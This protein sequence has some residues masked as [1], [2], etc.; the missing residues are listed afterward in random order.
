MVI[1]LFLDI[2]ADDIFASATDL[3]GT[4]IPPVTQTTDWLFR[5]ALDL[6]EFANR[7]MGDFRNVLDR[8]NAC[9]ALEE[10]RRRLGVFA[11]VHEL[12]HN[13]G[14]SDRSVD[15]ADVIQTLA[16]ALRAPFSDRVALARCV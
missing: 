1:H 6:I 13:N 12:L 9:A 4:N 16:D 5:E 15:L 3:T 8:A 14:A 10:A 2:D 11:R 7:I